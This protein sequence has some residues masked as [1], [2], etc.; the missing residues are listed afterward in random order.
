MPGIIRLLNRAYHSSLNSYTMVF[1]SKNHL[2]GLLLILVS[3]IDVWSGLAG[4][5]SV[6]VANGVAWGL[7]LNRKNILSGFY[8]FNPLLTG[9]GLGIAFD[10]S[11]QFYLFLVA[12]ALSTLFITLAFEGLL[13]K[14]GLPYLTFP[15]LISIWIAVLAARNYASLTPAESGIYT[16]NAMYERGGPLMVSIYQWFGEVEWPLFIKTYFRSLGAIFFQSGLFAG[17]LVAAGLLISSRISF[18]L[19]MLG[20]ASAWLFYLLIGASMNELN[21]SFIGFN[22]I[23]TAIAIGGFFMVASRW[24]F[25]WV[26]LITPVISIITGAFTLLLEPMQLPVYSLPFNLMVLLFLYAMKFRDRMLLKPEAVIVQYYSPEKNLYIGSNARER[27]RGKGQLP[28]SLPFFGTWKVSQGHNGQHTHKEEWRH[29]WDFVVTDDQ[30]R[31]FEGEGTSLRDYHCFGKPVTAPADGWIEEVADYIDDNPVGEVNIPQNW[32][33]TIVIRHSEWL[34]SKLSHLKKGSIKTAQGTF[35]KKGQVLAACGNSGRSP[36]PHLHFQIQSTPHIGSPTLLYPIDQYL[37]EAETPVLKL[38]D[39]PETDQLV[40]NLPA[41]PALNHAFG[42]KP[43]QT[44]RVSEVENKL[45]EETWKVMT[46]MYKNLFIEDES[47][48]ARAYFVTDGR[49]FFFSHFEGRQQGMLYLFYLAAFKIPLTYV[50]NLSIQDTYPPSSFAASPLLILQDFVAPFF[51]FIRPEFKL[52][53]GKREDDLDGSSLS[54]HTYCEPGIAGW[55]APSYRFRILLE[56]NRIQTL[57]VDSGKK[58]L[59]IRFNDYA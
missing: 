7:G 43:G 1:F 44:I 28:V 20:Y 50:R 27:F 54:L 4:L 30:G 48:G 45:T 6:A 15:F 32:G 16:M 52:E 3:F 22:H 10:P 26:I 24:S 40:S 36:Y 8:G 21:H 39:F 23:L 9:L 59:T 53:T 12:V 19:S 37:T 42:F 25:F 13:T 5:L 47:S 56:D 18:L 11:W 34:Y 31:E 35:V 58:K 38:Y 51:L 46:D 14:Y 2:L 29:A 33:N 55:A 49:L 17:I 41:E 57:D